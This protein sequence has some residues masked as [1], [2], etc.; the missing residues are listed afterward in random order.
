MLPGKENPGSTYAQKNIDLLVLTLWHNY[1]SGT[2]N[3][4]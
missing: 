1:V 3:G 2:G 4:T